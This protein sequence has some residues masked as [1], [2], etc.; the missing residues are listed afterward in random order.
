MNG[1]RSRELRA[2]RRRNAELSAFLAGILAAHGPLTLT[3]EQVSVIF[4]DPKVLWE[5]HEDG[6]MTFYPPVEVTR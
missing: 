4:D 1:K 6:S 5:A 3:H 2:V